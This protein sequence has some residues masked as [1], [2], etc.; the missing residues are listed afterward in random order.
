M[1]VGV[2][3]GLGFL[4]AANEKG[5]LVQVGFMKRYDPGIAYAKRFV[6]Q[7]MGGMLVLKAWYCD[8]A[9]RYT[10][11]DNLLPITLGSEKARRPEGDPKADRRRYYVLGHGSHLLDLARF[12]GGEV[13]SVRARLVERFGAYCWLAHVDFK[14]G[15]AGQLDLTVA[16]KMDWHESFQVY[17]ERGSVLGKSYLPWY[18][19]ASEVECFS[20]DDGVYRRPLGEDAHMYRLQIEG[21]ARRV[22]G[23]DEPY[24]ADADDGVAS[25]RLTVALARSAETGDA[26]RPDEVSGEV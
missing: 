14:S 24:A 16:V 26:V 19:R 1:G 18:D 25:T 12:L 2:A 8:S 22:F 15:A 23:E 20:V 21:F 17:G 4:D 10:F 11:T 9:Y 6:D 7:E 3:Q 13:E 5:V